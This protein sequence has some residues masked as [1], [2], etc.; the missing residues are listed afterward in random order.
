MVCRTGCI[1]S[2][3]GRV[4]PM[5][6]RPRFA[7]A[8]HMASR[9]PRTAT[10]GVVAP[11]DHCDEA[12]GWSTR[13]RFTTVPEPS[14]DRSREGCFQPGSKDPAA[15]SSGAPRKRAGF[16][17]GLAVP[18]KF[19]PLARAMLCELD[20]T[21]FGPGEFERDSWPAPKP[22]RRRKYSVKPGEFGVGRPGPLSSR[23]PGRSSGALPVDTPR[24]R[25][26][27]PYA[28]PEM[29]SREPAA[30]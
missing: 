30:S 21:L 22:I 13:A 16:A 9:E 24:C 3:G 28:G 7:G 5:S 6:A 29:R 2:H 19:R 26:H 23:R 4:T 8:C 1:G 10:V 25:G 17:Q 12:Q 11:G 18:E 27:S 20:C 14:C 15:G